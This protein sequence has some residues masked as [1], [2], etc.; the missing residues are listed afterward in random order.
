ML[1]GSI[2]PA[3]RY[4]RG[5]SSLPNISKAGGRIEK[6]AVKRLSLQKLLIPSR[7]ESIVKYLQDLRRLSSYFVL[8]AAA[9]MSLASCTVRK[10]Q[11]NALLDVESYIEEHP[12]SA[13]KMLEALSEEKIHG[14]KAE[15]KFSLLYSMAL[16][17]NYIDTT[18]LSII[19]PAVEYYCGKHGDPDS[20]LKAFFYEG[21]VYLN[22]LKCD[23]A[24]VSFSR[25]EEL[26]PEAT[27]SLYIGLLYSRI[28]DTYNMTRNFE[29]EYMYMCRAQ[30]VFTNINATKYYHTTLYRIAMALA[31]LTRYNESENIYR[32]L[33]CDPTVPDFLVRDIK[34]DY[35]LFLLSRPHRDPRMAFEL[36][37]EVLADGKPLRNINYNAAYAYTLSYCGYYE[38]SDEI[39]EQLYSVSDKEYSVVDSWKSAACDNEGRYKEALDLLQKSIGYVDSL[40]DVSRVQASMR[41]QR[42][43]FAMR[44]R[45]IQLENQRNRYMLYAVIAVLLLL[46]GTFYFVYS[47][48]KEKS[49]KE[50]ERLVGIAEAMKS[51]LLDSE[52][53]LA[54]EKDSLSELRYQYLQMYKSQFKDLGVLCETFLLAGEKKDSQRIVYEKVRRMIKEIGID[55]EGQKT[56]EDMIDRDLDNLMKHFREEF[57]KYLE[58]DYR[59]ISYVFVGFD[60][61]TLSIIFNMPSVDAAYMKKSRIRKKVQASGAVYRD[62]YLS[63]ME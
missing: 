28:S 37:S 49:A 9:L 24:I 21:A 6:S 51:R 25:A 43:Y 57:P 14:R 30:K 63:M 62:R 23:K 8:L 41:A 27:D 13:L 55:K 2:H 45:E 44:G 29:E 52:E 47:L 11:W 18:D 1:N 19:A 61:T 3:H 35:A 46:T 16:D 54:M 39:F 20:K 58:E 53:K 22:A 59:F 50:R 10:A 42:D 5:T 15:A 33:L 60:A 7:Q 26:V 4:L 32:E 56:F 38:E 12:D 48:R 34:E 36:F 31:N 40:A 17:K